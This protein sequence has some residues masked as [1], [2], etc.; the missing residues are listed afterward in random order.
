MVRILHLDLQPRGNDGVEFR[1]FW[2]HP[3][4][5]KRKDLPLKEIAAWGD[6]ADTD[7]YTRLPVDYAETGKALYNW[8]DGHNHLF[9]HELQKYLPGERMVLAI[10]ALERSANLPW[11]LLH[12]GQ[13]LLSAC[14]I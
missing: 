10:A 4:D 9:S 1:F 2:D 11:E 8:L 6:R 13:V 7:Y 12:D 5:F 14:P 3:N